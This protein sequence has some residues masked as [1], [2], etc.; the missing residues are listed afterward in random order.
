MTRDSQSGFT[1]I[2]T[3]VA[4]SVLAVSAVAFLSAVEA[5]VARIGGL[6]DRAIALWVLEN[7][8]AERRLNLQ[9]DFQP[10]PILGLELRIEVEETTTADPDLVR[11]DLRAL[12]LADG[13]AVARLTGFIDVGAKQR[14]EP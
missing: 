2:E 12:R 13:G 6:E 10:A 14:A 9:P 3:L 11:L 8:L 1:L 5:H 4:L 7:G